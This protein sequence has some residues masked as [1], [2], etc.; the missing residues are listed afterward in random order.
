MP[1]GPPKTTRGCLK[2]AVIEDEE[3]HEHEYEYEVMQSSSAY[4]SSSSYSLS[5]AQWLGWSAGGGQN[6]EVKYIVLTIKLLRF[7]P[8]ADSTFNIQILNANVLCDD[9]PQEPEPSGMFLSSEVIGDFTG[10][11]VVFP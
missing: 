9:E 6:I 7:P 10:F 1:S 5:N 4:S 3:E 8:A 11:A 2:N